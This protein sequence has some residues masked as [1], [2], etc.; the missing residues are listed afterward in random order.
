MSKMTE[1][2][3]II[4]LRN[5]FAELERVVNAIRP[6]ILGGVYQPIAQNVPPILIDIKK[7]PLPAPPKG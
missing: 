2:E 7:Q 4:D 3:L 1:Q 6:Q 5:K